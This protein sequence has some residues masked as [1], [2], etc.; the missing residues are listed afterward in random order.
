MKLETIKYDKALNPAYF[1]QSLKQENINLFKTN[2]KRLFE[3]INETES[4]EHNKNI[5]SD[6]LKNT[7]YKNDYE[8]N[9]AGRK[10]LVIHKGNTS[11]SPVAI[12][13]EA[14]SPKNKSEMMSF[15]K[16]NAKAFHETI[17]YFL[18]ERIVMQNKDIKHIIVTNSYDWFI[19]DASD[20]ETYFYANKTFRNK[21]TDWNDKKL[22]GNTTDWFYNEIAKPYVEQ[23]IEKL[24]CVYFNLNEYITV[25]TWHAL[26]LQDDNRLINLYKLL[27]PEHLL[28]LSFA[29][30]YNKIDTG[31]Y[32]EL[33]Y[34]LGLEETKQG[35]KKL[36]TRVKEKDRLYGSLMENAIVIIENH[37]R[38]T[39]IDRLDL[40]GATKEEQLFSIALELNIT[41]LNRILFLKLLEAQLIKYHK[42]NTDFAFLNSKKI[43][44][45]DELNELFFEVLAKK[46]QYRTASVN[47]NFGDLPYLNS[48]L[49]EQTKLEDNVIYISGLKD[50][51]KLP[52]SK[53]TVL[54][55]NEGNRLTGELN[56]LNYLFE[57]LN[58][59]NF[60]S[61]TKAE[62][63]KE[64][65]TIINA[66]VLGL[67]FEK[68]NGYK[69]G[70]FYTPSFITTYISRE[71]LKATILN[72]FSKIPNFGKVETWDDLKDKIEYSDK[73]QRQKA[74]D[75]INSLKIVDPAV[76]SG[77]FLVSV[78][79]EL[80][81]LKSELKLLQDEKGKRLRGVIIQNEN[82]E[83]VVINEE[84]SEPF[85]YYVNDKHVP[86]TEIQDIQQTLFN[87]KRILIEKCLF[88]VDINPKS[89][90]I[91][92][93]RL[94]IE[95]LKN[96]FYTTES[97]YKY[98]ET[99][100]NIDINIK[101]GNSLISKFDKGLNIFEK[102]AIKELIYKYK[103]SATAY[104]SATEY[105]IKIQN[106]TT[107]N[108]VKQ[109]LL[110]F[111]KPQDKHYKAFLTKT[112]ELENLQEIR[113]QTE[114]VKKQIVKLNAEV[115]EHEK[116]YKE[117][118]YNV[119]ANSLEW[120][121]EFPEI[122]DE[123]GDFIGFDI[124]LG[125]PPYFTISNEPKLKE[126]TDNYTIYKQTA[127]I[128]TL[129]IERGLQILQPD[130]K[131]S[132]IVSN[133]WLR[134]AYG[135]S[136][137]DFLLKNTTIDKL[138]DFDGLKVFD[139]ATVDTSIIE[140]T[141]HKNG[142]QTV[143]AVRFDKTFDLEN[144]SISEY[145]NKNKIELK[146]LTKES[147]NL[148]SEK[149]N[150]LKTKIEKIGKPL[151]NWNINI[152]RGITTGL[153][154]A[155]IIDTETKERLIM[156]DK[157]NKEIIK[158]L[159]RG[160]DIKQY[161]YEFAGLWVINTHNGLKAKNIKPIDAEKKYPFIYNHLLQ[162]MPEI[163][164][165]T[166]QGTHWSNLRNC[167]YL[168]EFEKEKIVF[169]KASQAKSFAYDNKGFYLQNTSYILT[170]ENIKYLLAILNSKL[171][172]YAFL[173][174]Y[175]SG[176]IEGEITVQAINE[177]P[178]PKISDANKTK[179][180]KMETL[181]NEIIKLKENDKEA[182]VSVQTNKIDKLV[183][184]LYDLTDEEIVLIEKQ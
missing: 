109:E 152:Y 51:L 165:R 157:K 107:I 37:H 64:N 31:F 36:I 113:P 141:K 85:Q 175:Q 8:I 44:D 42:G 182:D 25:G 146:D 181:V 150:A 140:V 66:A 171:I 118:Y 126:V 154:E 130:G 100:P 80:I 27:S 173:N 86:P 12:I 70:S 135:E 132:F 74:N 59:Y 78:L 54:K 24:D 144:S 11:G 124:V 93:L 10:D 40:F 104:K 46:T 117:N 76:G 102:Q 134:A 169:T 4:E 22:L 9:T 33:L 52:V 18:H 105:E 55:D 129:F 14:K 136:L 159:L 92:R 89:V 121:L 122:L 32:N 60:S 81:S 17:H 97:N 164:D 179:L 108:N 138:I 7:F 57:F 128:Y 50:R 178:I 20:F 13:I 49:F 62:I 15:D 75:L 87:E 180:D 56:T 3:R 176:G 84:T 142:K 35:G 103:T 68:I 172:T 131:L 133:K 106:I 183:Y 123:N 119:Y 79:N 116:R 2:F 98:L 167:A 148:K 72:N 26:S 153:N 6:F 48:S 82:D 125:N 38:L 168:T 45:F 29:N 23:E 155:F 21:Y 77:H 39:H 19:F 63:Q 115:A 145:F 47:E 91:C 156:K 95:L 112:R 127:D 161:Y 170:G 71:I 73:E 137:R 184:K 147:W 5:V 99:L 101:S 110:K 111:A 53:Q 149:E 69:D 16:P 34:I 94:W 96:S 114:Q 28:K 1:K 65:K 58:A 41:W 160:R 174:F 67:I 177:I 83:L 61:D 162:F 151:K 166:D 158:P 90:L 43:R 139:E 88:G 143:D 30:D 120:A 163:K